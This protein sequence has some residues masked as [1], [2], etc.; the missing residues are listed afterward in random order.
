[1]PREASGELRRLA[2]GFAARI[3][4]E[5]RAR[6]DFV[7][8]TSRTQE[9][10]EARKAALAQMAARL[11]RAGHAGKIEKLI[12]SGAK[13][14]TGRPWAAVV[15]AVDVLCAGT[16]D[17]LTEVP[18]FADFAAEW[19]SG[20]LARRFPDHVREKRSSGRDEELLR[21]YVLPHVEEVRLDEFTLEDAEIVMAHVPT[22][23][24]A[25]TRRH[26]AQTMSRLL[27]LAVYPGKYIKVSPIPRRW[28]PKAGND[29]AKECLYP[30]EDRALLGCTDI[31]LLRRFAYGFLDREGMRTD[32]LARLTWADV[33]LVHNRVDLDENKTDA[34]R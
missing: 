17:A 34:P 13:A 19:T 12:A 11:R 9:E 15:Q 31:P 21:L 29:K 27:N 6:R 14:R 26:V 3:T 25:G 30:D 2:D 18:T 24:A 22:A 32:E 8:T 28:L 5:G 23:R 7:L 4:I 33:D 16:I 20:K 10:A 1:M